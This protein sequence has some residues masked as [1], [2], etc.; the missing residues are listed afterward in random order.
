M[1]VAAK[2][3]TDGGGGGYRSMGLV[4]CSWELG[5]HVVAGDG[6]GDGGGG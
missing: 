5:G 6:G 2:V 1:V 4:W 3:E